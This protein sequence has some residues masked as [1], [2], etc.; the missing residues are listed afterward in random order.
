MKN[1]KKQIKKL[2]RLWSE[3]IYYAF[4]GK[5]EKCGKPVIFRSRHSHHIFHRRHFGTRWKIANGSLLHPQHHNPIF[6][7]CREANENNEIFYRK[8]RGEAIYNTLRR[9]STEIKHYSWSDLLE[10]EESLKSFIEVNK[11]EE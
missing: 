10:I 9:Q 11:K 4:G 2:D 5:C 7:D 6:H 8:K 1:R 3:A